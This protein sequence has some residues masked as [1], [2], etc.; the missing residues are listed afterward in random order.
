M[1][2]Y[3]ELVEDYMGASCEVLK[4][5]NQLLFAGALHSYDDDRDELTVSLRKGMETPQGIIYN[6]PVKLHVQTSPSQGNVLLL[7]GLVTRCAA[8]FWKIALKQTFSC[9]E[10][11][12][13]FRQAISIPAMVARASDPD[14]TEV[15]CKTM[16]VSLT[17][18]R[19]CNQEVYEK[20]EHLMIS[21]LQFSPGGW[22]HAFPCTVQ[23]VQQIESGS[24]PLFA[25]GCSFD[26]ITERQEDRLFQ[27]LF[28]LQVK[29]V[30]R[31]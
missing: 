10:R 30:N 28:A 14:A 31:K 26:K 29:T 25:Y 23:R 1:Q 9:A 4:L 13:S 12:S 17:G 18:L 27:D 11:R 16:D 5:D 3:K 21:S 15:P 20:G 24:A 22:P 7:Y 6:T 2:D 19:F 8:D